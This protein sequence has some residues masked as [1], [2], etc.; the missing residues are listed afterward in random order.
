MFG[1]SCNHLKFDLKLAMYICHNLHTCRSRTFNYNSLKELNE[2]VQ[3]TCID[4]Y[5]E[6]AQL[7]E[8]KDDRVG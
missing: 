2:Q 6:R 3:C 7:V 4:Q 8:L 5:M 1:F